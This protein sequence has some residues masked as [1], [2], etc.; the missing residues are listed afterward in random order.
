MTTEINA[1]AQ[2]NARVLAVLSAVAAGVISRISG[3]A[4][5]NQLEGQDMTRDHL[6]MLATAKLVK[7]VKNS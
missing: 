6:T 7:G 3:N 1:R 2:Q 5:S 4:L